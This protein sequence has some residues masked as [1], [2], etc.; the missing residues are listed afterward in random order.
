MIVN[1]IYTRIVDISELYNT[2]SIFFFMLPTD[3]SEYEH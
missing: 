3:L 2:K 1:A